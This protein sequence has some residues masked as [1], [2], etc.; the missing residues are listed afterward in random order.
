MVD[1]TDTEQHEA[2]SIAVDM[3]M[4]KYHSADAVITTERVLS[5]VAG[6]ATREQHERRMGMIL[7]RAWRLWA[8]SVAAALGELSPAAVE[9]YFD[10]LQA[11]SRSD[12]V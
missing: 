4:A 7:P 5:F 8:D 12:A 3:I 11:I 2:F 10:S 9:N 1:T 6:D